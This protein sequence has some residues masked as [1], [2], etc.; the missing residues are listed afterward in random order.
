MNLDL[1]NVFDQ[2]MKMNSN[3]P[4]LCSAMAILFF[5]KREY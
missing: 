5:I 3:D 2:A 1:I 4:E